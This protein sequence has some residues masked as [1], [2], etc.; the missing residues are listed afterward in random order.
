MT[1]AMIRKSMMVLIKRPYLI[2]TGGKELLG[3]DNL[4][5]RVLKST[6][7]IKSPIGG[8][9]ISVTRELT[10]FPKAVP[11]IIPIAKSTILPLSAKSL[12]SFIKLMRISFAFFKK[13][14]SNFFDNLDSFHIVVNIFEYI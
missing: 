11:I 14:S 4:I 12:N 8:I 7:P 9:N 13:Y 5:E 10:T 6:P 1:S 2:S 3:S